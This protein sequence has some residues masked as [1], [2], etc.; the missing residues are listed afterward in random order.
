LPQN[1]R[2][3]LSLLSIWQPIGVVVAS[4]ITFGTVPKYRCPTTTPPLPACFQVA[5]GEPCCSPSSNFGWRVCCGVLGGI[6]LLVF[7]A[8][9]FL[10]DF[11]E[12]PKYLIGRGKEEAA[13]EVL[14]KI[15]R[16]NKCAPPELTM[17]HF[18]EIDAKMGVV[19]PADAE[20]YN[21]GRKLTLWQT[22]KRVVVE[23]AKRIALLRALFNTP[24][25]I[26]IGLS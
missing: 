22:T 26:S 17:E 10:F 18:A 25:S 19:V 4:A 7:I 16:Y 3:L 21:G 24:V 9:F 23:G 14:H 5:D 20:L 11:Q 8:R 2:F 12:S 6:T 1:R 13:I 15:A